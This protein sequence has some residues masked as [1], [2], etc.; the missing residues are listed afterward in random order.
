MPRP[1]LTELDGTGIIG[2][3][4]IINDRVTV[5]YAAGWVAPLLGDVLRVWRVGPTLMLTG[6]GRR[7]SGVSAII[8]TLPAGY[9]P[10]STI[11]VPV[12]LDA[13]VSPDNLATRMLQISSAGTLTL[14]NAVIASVDYYV[15]GV[16]PL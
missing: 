1:V 6:G 9:R 13:F 12:L 7:T 2:V 4:E 11:V 14:T 10:P 5:P 8:G 15:N 16:L 3:A